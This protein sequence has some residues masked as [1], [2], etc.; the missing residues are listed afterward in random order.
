MPTTLLLFKRVE[1]PTSILRLPGGGALVA[2]TM[3]GVILKTQQLMT[4]SCV[5]PIHFKPN[6]TYANNLA[7][8]RREVRSHPCSKSI[9]R[10]VLPT[11]CGCLR[12]PSVFELAFV[13]ELKFRGAV[14]VGDGMQE[15]TALANTACNNSRS[16]P[17]FPIGADVVHP[18]AESGRRETLNEVCFV[19]QSQINLLHRQNRDAVFFHQRCCG[20]I[21]EDMMI[22]SRRPFRWGS[23]RTS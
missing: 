11:V 12:G 14:S 7:R 1:Q 6:A 21:L 13:F 19:L 23:R 20:G 2:L 5:A 8:T 18:R 9:A 10:F 22:S 3:H 4:S 16:D 17:Q 15:P